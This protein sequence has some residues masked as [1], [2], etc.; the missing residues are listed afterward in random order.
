[1]HWSETDA[2][3]DIPDRASVEGFLRGFTFDY[4]TMSH[5]RSV[6]S[7]TDPVSRY[8]DDEVIRVIASRL[9]SRQL[10]LR[11]RAWRWGGGSSGGS[12]GR[13]GAT[14]RSAAGSAKATPVKFSSTTSPRE[15]SASDSERRD[16]K[17]WIEIQLADEAGQTGCRRIL[18]DH[19]AG[20]G[21]GGGY[22]K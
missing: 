6:L 21:S 4:T 7:P 19:S 13:S 12:G 2:Y 16:K 17:D 18:P 22:A 5:L 20:S 10:V 8:S 1:M 9:V 3:V 14:D 15:S 11:K